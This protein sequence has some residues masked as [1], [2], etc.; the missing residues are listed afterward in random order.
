MP[1]SGAQETSLHPLCEEA[2]CPTSATLP[3]AMGKPQG[4]GSSGLCGPGHR[5]PPPA[6]GTTAAPGPCTNSSLTPQEPLDGGK[7]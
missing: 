6:L 7:H 2:F 1:G 5:V 3:M 4:P